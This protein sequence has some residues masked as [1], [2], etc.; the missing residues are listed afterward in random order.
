MDVQL[1]RADHIRPGDLVVHRNNCFFSR[2][3]IQVPNAIDADGNFRF[4][5]LMDGRIGTYVCDPD[6]TYEIF[7]TK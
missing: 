4:R 7:K 5:V 6:E 3:V 2:L 1:I